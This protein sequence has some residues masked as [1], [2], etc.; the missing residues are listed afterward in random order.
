MKRIHLFEFED[1]PWFPHLIREAMTD[2]LQFVADKFDIY[3]PAIPILKKGL[4]K[5]N[6][7]QIV[8]IGSG[9]GGGILNIYHHLQEENEDL[10]I[11]L[12]DLHPN[13]SAFKAISKQ[14]N[15]QIEFV[16][17]PVDATNVPTHL[18]GLRLQLLSF[19]HFEPQIAQQILKNAVDANASIIILE[20]HERKWAN[21]LSML[22]SPLMV[23]LF[24]PFIKPFK[25]SRMLF[26][27]LIPII[28]LFVLWDG[29]VS[30]LRTYTIE[31]L[32]QMSALIDQGAYVWE[33]GKVPENGV[34]GILYLLGYP[35]Q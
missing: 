21:M 23:L 30:I 12:T 31:E 13:I 8:D 15:G 19:H 26:T 18:T 14:T 5:S 25:L 29:M 28:P 10:K 34:I 35:H 4:E 24:T 17:T 22:F 33:I 3:K 6:S 16:E 27:Y 2:Y 20:A 9:S 1:L 7:D 32:N 11:T